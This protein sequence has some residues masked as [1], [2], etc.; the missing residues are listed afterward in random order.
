MSS[1]HRCDASHPFGFYRP[2]NRQCLMKVGSTKVGC[3]LS[4]EP[5]VS[6]CSHSQHRGD[7]RENSNP[8]PNPSASNCTAGDEFCVQEHSDT[9]PPHKRRESLDSRQA[10]QKAVMKFTATLRELCTDELPGRPFAFRSCFPGSAFPP[11]LGQG[12]QQ[13]LDAGSAGGARVLQPKASFLYL[14][15]APR[16]GRP[17]RCANTC[18]AQSPNLSEPQRDLEVASH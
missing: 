2:G 14:L 7:G 1:A 15:A 9:R 18:S 16:V 13:A 17:G 11:Q 10:A 12:G 8:S 3:C 5:L 4:H 6:R